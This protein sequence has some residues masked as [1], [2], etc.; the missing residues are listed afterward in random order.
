MYVQKR[1]DAH[2]VQIFYYF[3][4]IIIL[5]AF[6]YFLSLYSCCAYRSLPCVGYSEV[7]GRPSDLL[8]HFSQKKESKYQYVCFFHFL[9][10]SIY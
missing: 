4:F 3:L 9:L 8:A 10:Y 5:C 1:N 6:V 7:V 2:F